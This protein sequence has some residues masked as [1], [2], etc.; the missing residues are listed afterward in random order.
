[1]YEYLH[2][3]LL[4][5]SLSAMYIFYMSFFPPHN[6]KQIIRLG[7]EQLRHSV[8]ISIEGNLS[9]CHSIY[10]HRIVNSSYKI[11]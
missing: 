4:L 1:M 11:T 6:K 10:V 7:G 5:F 2:F 9:Q 3:V 8:C